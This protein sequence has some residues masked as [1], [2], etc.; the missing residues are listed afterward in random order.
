[1]TDFDRLRGIAEREAREHLRDFW[2][3]NLVECYGD[4]LTDA[5]IDEVLRMIRTDARIPA[6]P[7]I[8][9]TR[10]EL[11]AL[12]PDTVLATRGLVSSLPLEILWHLDSPPES[13]LSHDDL[14]PA[15]VVAT[16]DQT[17]AARQA[18]EATDDLWDLPSHRTEEG[19]PN[20]STCDGGGCPDCTDPA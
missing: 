7:R 10:E 8:I 19:Y 9:R 6:P 15:V 4:T 3:V 11:A 16:G 5:E 13:V 1:M 17:R 12:D 2:R 20:C 14:L 18:L